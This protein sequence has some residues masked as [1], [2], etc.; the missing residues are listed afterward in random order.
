MTKVT[1]EGLLDGGGDPAWSKLLDDNAVSVKIEE[2]SPKESSTSSDL[3]PPGM[4]VRKESIFNSFHRQLRMSLKAVSESPGP[5]S[6]Y[7]R[8]VQGATPMQ[9]FIEY[10]TTVYGDIEAAGNVI[11]S[12][13]RS[14]RV[15]ILGD[16][17]LVV[18]LN[19]EAINSSKCITA[20]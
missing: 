4:P 15:V 8:S 18:L 2:E 10:I 5:I 3:P 12:Q 13:K 16:I 11:E 20:R 1:D 17:Y 14:P 7:S 9:E 19:T 6:R